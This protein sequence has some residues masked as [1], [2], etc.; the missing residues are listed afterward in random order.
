[1]KYVLNE[2]EVEFP[3][4]AE[5]D[6]AV[7]KARVLRSQAVRDIFVGLGRF[8][9]SLPAKLHNRHVKKPV[10]TASGVIAAY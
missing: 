4:Q 5:I 7:A 6:E 9:K 8:L 3:S 1:M 2:V 10:A